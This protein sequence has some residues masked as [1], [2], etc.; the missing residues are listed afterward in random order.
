MRTQSPDTSPEIEEVQIEL[1]REAPPWRKLIMVGQMNRT[2]RELALVGLRQRYPGA[3][4][5][6]L[7]RRLA[8]ILLDREIATRVYGWDPEVEGY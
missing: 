5:G 8:A 7:K 4:P 1:L 3:S 2:I 6:D